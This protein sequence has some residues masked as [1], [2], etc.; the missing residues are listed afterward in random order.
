MSRRPTREHQS[1]YFA[2]FT[3]MLVGVLFVLILMV[4]FLAF[5]TGT[6]KTVPFSLFEAVQRELEQVKAENAELK[7]ELA[8]MKLVKPLESYIADGQKARD[9]IVREVV[10]ELRALQI[11]AQVGRS[12]N[13]VTISGRNLFGSGRSDLDSVTGAQERVER[14]AG[15]LTEKIRCYAF[16]ETLTT[17]KKRV[18]KECNPDLLFVEAVF[19][20][21]HTDNAPVTANL[22]DGIDSNLKLSARRATNTYQAMVDA[23]PDLT[24]F[25]NPDGLQALSVAAYGEQRPWVENIDRAARE[26]NRRIDIRFDMYT[27]KDQSALDELKA[28]FDE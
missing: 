19:V 8:K 22:G 17:A 1:N 6:E 9:D 13:V 21:G 10:E 11:D 28:R 24:L 18:V 14:L 7:A 25:K 15:V 20:E 12:S 5:Q 23:V 2:S 16:A 3:D 26:Q 4:A 27:P